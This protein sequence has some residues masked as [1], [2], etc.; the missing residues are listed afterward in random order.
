MLYL[1]AFTVPLIYVFLKVF[2]QRNIMAGELTRVFLTSYLITAF[3]IISITLIAT[4]G[5]GIFIPLATGGAI[6]GVAAIR[7][8]QWLRKRDARSTKI[9]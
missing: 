5:W 1:T 9:R 6:G 2:Q 4:K 7:F 8:H 3:E